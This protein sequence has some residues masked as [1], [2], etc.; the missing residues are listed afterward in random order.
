MD[1][2]V[3]VEDLRQN[4]RDFVS[5]RKWQ[6]RSAYTVKNLSIN[7]VCEAAELME[8]FL[9]SNEIP[10]VLQEK[11]KEVRFESADIMFALLAFCNRFEIDL[12]E[13]LKERMLTHSS[14][15]KI[16]NSAIKSDERICMDKNLTV[17]DLK[18]MVQKFVDE[19][20]WDSHPG[21][22]LK[23]LSMSISCEAAELMEIFLWK[24]DEEAIKIIKDR[25][26]EIRHE[27]ADIAFS[28]LSFCNKAS[29]DLS[30]AMKEKIIINAQ[31][32]PI[33]D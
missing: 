18:L 11:E 14:K 28:L 4:V 8:I 9:W 32:Y 24:T 26:K 22:N 6:Q 29:I 23:D 17:Q 10:K 1:Q 5:A 15:Y 19:R 7:I 12:S 30:T 16:E 20:N 33:R 21:R 2:S 25:E 3:T 13:S 31:K 27:V